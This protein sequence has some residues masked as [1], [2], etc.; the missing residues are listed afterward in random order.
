MVTRYID[1]PTIK[2]LFSDSKGVCA[3]CKTSLFPNGN[4]VG[5][6]CHIEAYSSG[7]ARFNKNLKREKKENLYDN[8][9]V[10]CSNCHMEIDSRENN[11]YS[12][13]FLQKL[14][15]NHKTDERE[16][17]RID[18]DK[19]TAEVMSKNFSLSIETELLEIKSLINTITG[20]FC[21]SLLHDKFKLKNRFSPSIENISDFYFSDAELD[22]IDKITNSLNQDIQKSYLLIGPPSTGKTTLILKI[23]KGISDFYK[24]FYISLKEDFNLDAIRK[25]LNYIKNFQSVIYVDDCHLNNKLAYNI[26]EICSDNNNLALIFCYRE[27]EAVSSYTDDG[28]SLIEG[29][30][31]T[32]IFKI[33]KVTPDINEKVNTLLENRMKKIFDET[34]IK[35]SI[36]D[37]DKV[38]KLINNNLLKLTLLLDEWENQ[39]TIKLEEIN[40]NKL[41]KFLF[42]RFFPESRY[43]KKELEILKIYTSINKYEIPFRILDETNIENQLLKDALLIKNGNEFNFF[44]PSF[45]HLLLLALISNDYNF[46]INYPLGIDEFEKFAFSNYIR[47]LLSISQNESIINLEF[48][49][50]KI[51]VNGGTELFNY[52][53]R[54]AEIKVYF[55][56]NSKSIFYSDEKINLFLKNLRVSL[57]EQYDYYYS[58]ILGDLEIILTTGIVRFFNRTENFG[59]ITPEDCTKDVFVHG[60]N[61]IGESIADGD[62]VQFEVGQGTKG[63][64]A[65]NVTKIA[66][67]GVM[68]D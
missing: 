37:V 43:E 8:L 52:L 63:P 64:E 31:V 57:S 61:V 55:I 22:I 51:L 35:P 15:R 59:F 27:I 23:S 34:K 41:N 45:S 25:D 40:D 28:N 4:L 54:E 1:N 46:D 21:F 38:F 60:T 32:E 30:I 42:K 18:I 58:H 39:P 29:K 6:I 53:V 12:T 36:V 56:N 67:A 17:C 24:Q 49:L 62:T 7:G 14:K 44:H 11:D 50:N 66:P 47:S 16:D 68:I 5:V 10:L 33:E 19:N 65:K 20:N 9:I 3:L 13:E 48:M 2:R 26:F